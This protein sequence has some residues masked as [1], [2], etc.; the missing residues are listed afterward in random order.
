[1]VVFDEALGK[2]AVRL[3]FEAASRMALLTFV[4]VVVRFCFLLR[5]LRFRVF[6]LE[7]VSHADWPKTW[8][9]LEVACFIFLLVRRLSKVPLDRLGLTYLLILFLGLQGA[10][11]RHVLGCLVVQANCCSMNCL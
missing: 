11:A 5:L 7:E 9:H 6:V 2:V 4:L 10:F 3:A 1:M 8:H